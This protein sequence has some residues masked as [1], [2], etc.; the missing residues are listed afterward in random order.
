MKVIFSFRILLLSAALH[1]ICINADAEDTPTKLPD[2]GLKKQKLFDVDGAGARTTDN[3]KSNLFAEATNKEKKKE[4]GGKPKKST[5]AGK[6]L[7]EHEL[8]ITTPAPAD[9]DLTVS[10]HRLVD[11]KGE[12]TPYASGTVTAVGVGIIASTTI[13]P[14]G[15]FSL[16]DV[17]LPQ[18]ETDVLVSAVA[19][20]GS[21]MGETR[22]LRFSYTL[23]SEGSSL[24]TSQDGGSVEIMDPDSPVA[25]SKI[26][27]QP[28]AAKRDI[29]IQVVYDPEHVPSVP[30][31]YIDVGPPVS[32]GPETETFNELVSLSIPFHPELIP[33]SLDSTYTKVLSLTEEGWKEVDQAWVSAENRLT[34]DVYALD[35]MAYIAVVAVPLQLDQAIIETHPAGAM[36]YVD[37]V[38]SGTSPAVIH[39]LSSGAHTVRIYLPGYNEKFFS[40]ETS[41]GGVVINEVLEYAEDPKPVVLLEVEG[42][43]D[44][45]KTSSSFVEI[46][47]D[48]MF[49]GNELNDGFGVISVNGKETMQTITDGQIRGY[50][51]LNV[52]YNHVEVRVTGPNGNTGVSRPAVITREITQVASRSRTKRL[53]R[54]GETTRR[55]LEVNANKS[56]EIK[57]VLSWDTENTDI[58]LHVF[59]PLGNHAFYNDKEGI[60]GAYIDVDDT[61]GYGPEIF[62]YLSPV[63]GAYRVAIDAYDISY[64]GV[65]MPTTASLEITVGGSIIFSGSYLF[66]ESDGN[67]SEGNP[68]G[69]NPN[70]FWDAFTFEIGSLAITSVK[71][72][73]GSNANAGQHAIFTTKEGENEIFI[74]TSAPEGISDLDIMYDIEEVAEGFKVLSPSTVGRSTSFFCRT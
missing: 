7:I 22:T 15:L 57:I 14:S 13:L 30:F 21:A 58:D 24:V 40:F 10:E 65:D 61:D 12:I 11:I 51:S 59:D 67:E 63:P 49:G 70:A 17:F 36:L 9:Q 62:S 8:I 18:G 53:L 48:V 25:G 29:R 50:V 32:F 66:T 37:G 52:G 44:G 43:L 41:P 39:A 27:V 55:H 6:N 2:R 4:K 28:G 16:E 73:D 42:Y 38:A 46:V 60:P 69:T 23:P 1:N 26:E 33:D 31:K 20:D 54:L 72:Y 47:A 56:N 71:T 19:D 68:E 34:F 64:N 3:D 74:T 35:S 45:M 5:K